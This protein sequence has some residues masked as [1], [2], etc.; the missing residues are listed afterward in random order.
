VAPLTLPS[1]RA[2]MRAVAGASMM[3]L[4]A[5]AAAEPTDMAVKAAFLPR[6]ARYV[7]W[8]QT[9]MPR[10]S[11]PFVLCLLGGDPFDGMLDEAARSQSV[12]GRRIVVR[13]LD[14]PAGADGCHIA[15][16]QGSKLRPAAQLLAALAHKPVLTVTDAGSATQRGIIHF[17]VTGG[18]VRFYIDQSSAS[19]RGIIISSR[20]LALAVGVRQ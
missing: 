18:R 12:D 3:V 11:D 4:G 6:F 8:P 9:A 19:Q 10:G 14:N 5:A 13:R 15:F 20:L 7:S 17:V 2:S 1:L 16:I